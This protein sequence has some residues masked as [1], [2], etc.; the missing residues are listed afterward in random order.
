M[1]NLFFASLLILALALLQ[2]C[3]GSDLRYIMADDK[4]SAY[5]MEEIYSIG[6]FTPTY[7]YKRV[8]RCAVSQVKHDSGNTG[9][10]GKYGSWTEDKIS[11]QCVALGKGDGF[12]NDVA[13]PVGPML[14]QAGATAGSG[15]LIGDGIRDSS[16]TINN[17][18]SQSQG[19]GQGQAQGQI[20]LQ[21][22]KSGG[23]CRG[24]CGG[25]NNGRD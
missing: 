2:G 18:N 23:G 15:A 20:Q 16:D 6:L 24:N 25:G 22:Q 8:S 12:S 7:Q 9:K 21:G 4:K 13:S 14:L 5:K 3:A 1:K 17:T 11:S 10:D 19:Q